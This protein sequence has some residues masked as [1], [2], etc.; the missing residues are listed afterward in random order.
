V[1]RFDTDRNPSELRKRIKIIEGV[2]VQQSQSQ[3][4]TRGPGRGESTGTV[5]GG[6]GSGT[7]DLGA[8]MHVAPGAKTLPVRI[9]ELQR[10]QSVPRANTKTGERG[11]RVIDLGSD[12][13]EQDQD[14][15]Q[16]DDEEDEEDIKKHM[17]VVSNTHAPSTQRKA[18]VMVVID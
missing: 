15:D 16:D 17:R 18:K 10:R 6:S 7:R 11:S 13:D 9:S 3:S 5:V 14:Q 8:F 12:D 1:S 2:G 4:Q